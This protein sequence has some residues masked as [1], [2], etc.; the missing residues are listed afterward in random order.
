[1]KNYSKDEF[2]LINLGDLKKEADKKQKDKEAKTQNANEFGFSTLTTQL[3][4]FSINP[5]N[6]NFSA[7]NNFTSPP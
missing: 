6:S 5:S 1:L 4:Q 2:D 7:P 3:D